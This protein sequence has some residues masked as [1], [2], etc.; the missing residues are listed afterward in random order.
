MKAGVI[1]FD[2]PAFYDKIRRTQATGGIIMNETEY[3]CHFA[4][5]PSPEYGH[6]TY[7]AR[8]WDHCFYCK[9]D[10]N[11]NDEDHIVRMEELEIGPCYIPMHASCLVQLQIEVLQQGL[12]SGHLTEE[13]IMAAPVS[14]NDAY[15]NRAIRAMKIRLQTNPGMKLQ[16]N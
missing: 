2:N 14:P 13:L 10:M 15:Y 11:A 16:Y 1:L 6:G 3:A 5:R 4:F 9:R 7:A 12:D 8:D